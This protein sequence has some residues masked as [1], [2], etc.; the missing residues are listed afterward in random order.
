MGRSE[1]QGEREQAVAELEYEDV[2]LK[3]NLD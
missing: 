2:Q 1:L 3:K